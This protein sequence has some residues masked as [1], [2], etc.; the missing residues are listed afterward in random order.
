MLKKWPVPSTV[1]TFSVIFYFSDQTKNFFRIP[2]IRSKLWPKLLLCEIDR[3]PTEGFLDQ[4]VQI[5]G[6]PL[7]I[8][9]ILLI[10]CTS[11]I[12]LL[13]HVQQPH[14]I[15]FYLEWLLGLVLREQ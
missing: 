4:P 7:S 11:Y 10:V 2:L 3:L 15:S 1:L 13:K 6:R 12:L 14:L 5:R 9:H 8:L